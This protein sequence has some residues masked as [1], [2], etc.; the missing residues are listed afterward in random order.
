MSIEGRLGM[1]PVRE[2]QRG[3]AT[4][5][6]NKAAKLLRKDR[7]TVQ[8]MIE[9]GD[10]VGGIYPGGKQNRWWV[11]L[12]Q[13][14]E[15][16]PSGDHAALV[17]R[18]AALVAENTQL[19]AQVAETHGL[20]TRL[21]AAEAKIAFQAEELASMR[22]SNIELNASVGALLAAAEKRREGHRQAQDAVNSA[23]D[24]VN[25]AMAS[26]TSYEQ[27]G[28]ELYKVISGLQNTLSP[29]LSPSNLAD[30]GFPDT[31]S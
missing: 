2:P 31:D 19:K 25:S 1:A 20:R 6:A 15:T 30:M 12:D 4:V 11:Y 17:A 7:R 10:L 22:S 28:A 16:P 3:R 13:L 27:A 9:V 5:S 8:A 29:H 24:A 23:T 21:T 18:N 26:A 14:V